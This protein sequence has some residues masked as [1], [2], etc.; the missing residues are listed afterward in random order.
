[1]KWDKDAESARS[2]LQATLSE[3]Q[4]Q[5]GAAQAELAST[6]TSL[7]QK[8]SALTE[9]QEALSKIQSEL[10]E[11]LAR[12]ADL[13]LSSEEQ[14]RKLEEELR[15]ALADRDAAASE[16]RVLQTFILL[17]TSSRLMIML[18]MHVL[19]SFWSS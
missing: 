19:L 15:Q 18:L 12:L 3:T 11:S 9:T 10:Q 7:S 6:Q 8:N 4:D 5:L 2:V 13:Q 17:Y 14:S 1:M 16:S